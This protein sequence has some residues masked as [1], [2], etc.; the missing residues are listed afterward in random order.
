MANDLVLFAFIGISGLLAI[1][2]VLDYFGRKD[3]NAKYEALLRAKVES[4]NAGN[5]VKDSHKQISALLDKAESKI[6]ELQR[7]CEELAMRLRRDE[8]AGYSQRSVIPQAIQ[9]VPPAYSAPR[10]RPRKNPVGY[11]VQEAESAFRNEGVE[12]RREVYE[13]SSE[14]Q[15]LVSASV[16]ASSRPLPALDASTMIE[17]KTAKMTC[18]SCLNNYFKPKGMVKQEGNVVTQEVKCGICGEELTL[19][20]S[21]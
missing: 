2:L 15:P 9:E 10:G 6:F 11:G 20:A 8:L 1:K 5:A 13:R 14:V 3:V 12:A 4:D 7:D 16:Q 19:K 17:L 21:L 18:P